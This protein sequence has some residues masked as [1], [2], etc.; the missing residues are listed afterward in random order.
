MTDVHII[1]I[2]SILQSENWKYLHT[3]N[4]NQSFDIFH[5][6]LIDI[7]DQLSPEVLVRISAKHKIKILVWLLLSVNLLKN[8]LNFIANQFD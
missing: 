8:C 1:E 4:A 2:S 6:R 7:L 3:L 5:N